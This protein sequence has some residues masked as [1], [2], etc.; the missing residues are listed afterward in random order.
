MNSTHDQHW[1][2]FLALAD[3]AVDRWD[4][5]EQ[6]ALDSILVI[7]PPAT[8]V[9]ATLTKGLA[10]LDNRDRIPRVDLDFEESCRRLHEEQVEPMP[11][12]EAILALK[13]ALRERKMLRPAQKRDDDSIGGGH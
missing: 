5:R 7:R 11:T 10:Q 8:A 6:G 13:E 12:K 9:E 4:E 3:C 2:R 1:D